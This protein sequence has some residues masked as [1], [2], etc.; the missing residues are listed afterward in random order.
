MERTKITQPLY[1]VFLFNSMVLAL[2]LL[3]TLCGAQGAGDR[4][5]ASGS[6]FVLLNQPNGKLL[7]GGYGGV[8]RLNDD[9][10]AD[11]GFVATTIDDTVTAIALQNDGRIVIGGSF[12]HVGGSEHKHIARLN[13][14]GSLDDTFNPSADSLVSTLAV[15]TDGKIVVGGYFTTINAQPRLYLA[16]LNPNGSSDTGFNPI[17]STGEYNG[18]GELLMQANG[19]LLVGGAFTQVDGQIRNNLARLNADGTLDNAFNPNVNSTVIALRFQPDGKLLV[20]GLFSMVGTETRNN[21]ARLNTNG[22]LDSTF[23]PNANFFVYAVALQSDGKVVLTGS[24]TSV[25]GQPRNRIAG[26]NADGTLEDTFDPNANGD[27]RDV[28]LRPDGKLVVGGS[29]TMIGGQSHNYIVRLNSDGSVDNGQF[30][31]QNFDQVVAP[32]LP[33]GWT[34]SVISGSVAP[35][36]SLDTNSDTSPNAVFAADPATAT[37]SVLTSPSTRITA[38][39]SMF[40]FRHTYSMENKLDGGVLEISIDGGAFQDLIDAGGTFSVGDYD[41]IL[42]AQSGDPLQGRMA[43]TGF[44]LGFIVTGVN[45][46]AVGHTVAVRWRAGSDPDTAGSGWYVDSI[47]CGAPPPPPPPAPTPWYFAARYPLEIVGQ[48]TTSIGSAEYSFGGL[49]ATVLTSNSYRFAGNTWTTIAPLPLAVYSAAVASDGTYA[50]IIGG[51]ASATT[52]AGYRYDPSSNTFASIAPSPTATYGSAAVY[53]DGRIYKIGG[54]VGQGATSSNAV[55]VYDVAVGTWSTVA[56]Y[57][58]ALGF[59]SAFASNHYIYAAGGANGLL[60]PTLKT[61]RYDPAANVWNDGAFAD[62]PQARWGA[63][64]AAFHNGG[65]VAGGYVGGSSNT[66]IST[67]ALQWLADSNVWAGLPNM[68]KARAR[69]GGGVLRGCFFAFGGLSPNGAGSVSGTRENQ[70]LDCVFYDGVDP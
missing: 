14:D 13:A 5:S 55:E 41:A 32:A 15:Q 18:V 69:F 39:N 33:E 70:A 22:M 59:V 65:L 19:Q 23:N 40:Y 58:T 38:A 63:A 49:A 17:L 6:V 62:L 45:L 54:F 51:V 52:S 42:Y 50:Y 27:V 64:S 34:A 43:W 12:T 30:C 29:F 28:A 68:L 61:Y 2:A 46:P 36:A 67:T 24:F 31:P 35:W 37:D 11:L 25:G 53:L 8:T 60:Q 1:T 56:P 10:S 9:G 47:G 20:G 57:P 48:G 16:R 7:V 26:V 66:L 3:P 44:S 4:Y 21:I